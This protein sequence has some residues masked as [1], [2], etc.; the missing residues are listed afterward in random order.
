MTQQDTQQT[1]A[2]VGVVGTSQQNPVVSIAI[3]W[4]VLVPVIAAGFALIITT[5]FNSVLTLRNGRKQ[6][7][8]NKK[9]DAIHVLV[10]SGMTKALSDLASAQEEIRVLREL[11]QS[12][13]TRMGLQETAERPSRADI[14][15]AQSVIDA[16]RLPS[17]EVIAAQISTPRPDKP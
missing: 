1:T 4:V 16:G 12:L 13:N 9:S 5:I 2:T 15:H 6:D 17:K 3:D 11:V 10:N 14:E 8:G 7:E